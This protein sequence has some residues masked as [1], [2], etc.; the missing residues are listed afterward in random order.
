MSERG[1]LVFRGRPRRKG[2]TGA[3]E[4]LAQLAAGRERWRFDERVL[5]SSGFVEGVLATTDRT[6]ADLLP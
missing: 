2:S 5:G 4:R 1:A 3:W 6:A